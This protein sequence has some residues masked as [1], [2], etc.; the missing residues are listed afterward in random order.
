MDNKYD[1]QF[2]IMK[3]VIESNNQGMKASKKDSDEKMVKLAEYFKSIL[4][5]ITYQINT[6]K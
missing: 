6:F 4:A 2:I 3:A 5:A 1:E